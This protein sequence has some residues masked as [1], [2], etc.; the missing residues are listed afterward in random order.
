M[1]A[2]TEGELAILQKATS[3]EEWNGAVAVVIGHG[4][5]STAFAL[6]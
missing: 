2:F 6:C 5:L 4:G 1:A 3:F